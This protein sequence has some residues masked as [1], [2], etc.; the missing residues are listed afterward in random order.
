MV[1]EGG[2]EG[3]EC[4]VSFASHTLSF[5]DNEFLL[6]K[7][8]IVSKMS[9]S[10]FPG[11]TQFQLLLT[12]FTCEILILY[13]IRNVP[14]YEKSNFSD[15]EPFFNWKNF[16]GSYQKYLAPSLFSRKNCRLPLRLYPIVDSWFLVIQEFN[17]DAL[18][19]R[20][21]DLFGILKLFQV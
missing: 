21:L 1:L 17:W 12:F 4:K 11:N 10:F 5:S 14:S 18:R 13:V 8:W 6:K 9:P 2:T 19:L 7:C 15:N 20:Y 16:G 3:R